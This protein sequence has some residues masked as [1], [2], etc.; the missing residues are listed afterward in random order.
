MKKFTDARKA[1]EARREVE[2]RRRIYARR[3]GNG[4]MS[5][6]EASYQIAVMTEIA[7]DYEDRVTASAQRGAAAGPE[8]APAK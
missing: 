2:Q 8:P 7:E 1:A 3:V 6:T 4:R 5:E